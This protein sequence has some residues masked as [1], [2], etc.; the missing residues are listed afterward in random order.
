[1]KLLLPEDEIDIFFNLLNEIGMILMYPNDPALS[2]FIILDPSFLTN[3]MVRHPHP[4]YHLLARV[5]PGAQV[6]LL[7]R[8]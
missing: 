3:V 4:N 1:M 7:R 2:D 6:S 5:F 8:S